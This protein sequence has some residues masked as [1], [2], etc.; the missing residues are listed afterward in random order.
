MSPRQAKN[1]KVINIG[2]SVRAR[3]LNIA[4][5]NNEDYNRILNQYAQERLIYRFSISRYRESFI[6]KGALLFYI[7]KIPRVR[8]TKDVDFLSTGINNDI[9]LIKRIIQE[10]VEI[11]VD[12]G[13]VFYTS[14]V[15]VEQIAEEAEYPGIRVSVRSSIG[16]ARNV[17]QIDIGFGDN[18]VA[19]PVWRDYPTL[20]DYPAPHI[21][22]YPIE[23]AIAE[24]FEAIVR[25]NIATSRMKDFYD[26]IF[27]SRSYTFIAETL[28]EAIKITF[29]TRG[30]LLTDSQIIWS[31]S[32][33]NDE[34]MEKQWS[35]FHVT[36][37]LRSFGSWTESIKMIEHFLLPIIEMKVVKKSKK[38]IWNC[39]IRKW[40]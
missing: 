3:L 7:Y 39:N 18:L 6:L 13:V 34:A 19:D 30:R 27:L 36:N 25:F 8:P 5:K 32:F 29:D 40:E 12:D 35:A 16:G 38:F 28:F 23:S 11:K 37:K 2:A 15:T 17:M 26:I 9:S 10:I 4:R 31:D 22:V 24:K 21:S 20:L 33:K 14:S 1:K